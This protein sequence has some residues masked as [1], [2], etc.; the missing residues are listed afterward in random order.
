MA[1][2]NK[3]MILG[4]LGADPEV[5][6][7]QS[8]QPIA[9][10]RIATTESWNDRQSG[11]RKEQTEWH[12]V[13]VFGRQAENCSKYLAKG[14]QVLVEGSIQTREWQDRDG[15]RRWTTEIKA[16]NVQFLGG[17]GDGPDRNLQGPPAGDP[18]GGP[19][20]PDPGFDQGFS[21]DEIPF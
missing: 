14:R 3:V 2:L 19:P 9:N 12:R 17:R 8:N 16:R 4:H 21:D 6:Y 13:V 11:E 18:G 20:G 10:L 7:T 15:N 1:S 5:R